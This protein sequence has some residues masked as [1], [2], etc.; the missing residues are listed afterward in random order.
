MWQRL[1]SLLL[2]FLGVA[3]LS[4]C[5]AL[6]GY[7]QDGL[8]MIVVEKNTDDFGPVTDHEI[9]TLRGVA[10]RCHAQVGEQLSS[11]FETVGV[12][13]VQYGAGGS[14]LGWAADAFPGISTWWYTLYGI[15]AGLGNGAT[16]GVGSWSYAK[17]AGVGGCIGHLLA[18][19]KTRDENIHIFTDV[20]YVRSKLPGLIKGRGELPEGYR[21]PDLLDKTATISSSASAPDDAR[22]NRVGDSIKEEPLPAA[23]VATEKSGSTSVSKSDYATAPAGAY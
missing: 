12:S 14:V 23:A 21:N 20:A 13:G 6:N 15:R 8:A 7:S 2:V 22:L 10:L 3:S 11:P 17:V 4:G 9:E 1:G 19:K 5:G 18:D 16:A